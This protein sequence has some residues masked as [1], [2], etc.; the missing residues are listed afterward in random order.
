M[1]PIGTYV[2]LCDCWVPHSS[3]NIRTCFVSYGMDGIICAL[4]TLVPNCNF[5]NAKWSACLCWISLLIK[6]SKELSN[7]ET[8]QLKSPMS[9]KDACIVI[10]GGNRIKFVSINVIL[11]QTY[12]DPFPWY[13]NQIA[14]DLCL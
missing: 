8:N 3:C 2:A 4:M 13:K 12:Y 6:V 9:Y 1:K 7:K 14:L 5:A 11:L 10:N